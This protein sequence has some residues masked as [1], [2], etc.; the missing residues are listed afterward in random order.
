MTC[1]ELIALADEALAGLDHRRVDFD[2]E[3][4]ALRGELEAAGWRAV[5]LV[6]MRHEHEPRIAA[7]HRVTEVP[8]D[9]VRDLQIAWH[10]E[11]YPSHELGGHL[12]DAREVAELRATRAFA[13]L[14]AGVPI[15][16]STLARIGA[17]AE[18]AEVFVAREHR[19]RGVGTA[20]TLA[21]IDAGR[22]LDDL[23]ICADDEDRPKQLYHRL[24]FRPAWTMTEFL[25]L[26]QIV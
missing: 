9:A 10:A 5:R 4:G 15:G 22:G 1:A 23:W 24:G 25:R 20:V 16:Y 18:I 21:S 2:P 13:V 8:Y 12:E 11:D 3:P 26:P 14:D 7:A 6:L 19:G 17:Q